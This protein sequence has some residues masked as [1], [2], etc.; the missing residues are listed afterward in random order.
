[1][2]MAF[3][4]LIQILKKKK[5]NPMI[6]GIV[7]LKYTNA[8]MEECHLGYSSVARLCIMY[9]TFF[10]GR[11]IHNQHFLNISMHV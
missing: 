6:L 5:N 9:L 11:L 8:I 2:C 1:M 3:H 4:I 10:I 7:I